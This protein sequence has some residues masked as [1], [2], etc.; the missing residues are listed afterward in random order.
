MPVPP[1]AP[2]PS[3]SCKTASALLTPPDREPTAVRRA[4]LATYFFIK[5]PCLEH[6]AM[7]TGCNHIAPC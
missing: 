5:A 7:S 4:Q 1:A 6:R 2:L 3:A